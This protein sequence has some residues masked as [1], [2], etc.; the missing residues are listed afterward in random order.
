M[1]CGQDPR[2]GDAGRQRGRGGA[3]ADEQRAAAELKAARAHQR[4]SAGAR[5]TAVPGFIRPSSRSTICAAPCG[6]R[7]SPNLIPG[8]CASGL[9]DVE[10]HDLAGAGGR[11]GEA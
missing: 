3:A 11:P 5:R 1:S 10:P 2:L 4:F 9:D 7:M 8:T 6:V